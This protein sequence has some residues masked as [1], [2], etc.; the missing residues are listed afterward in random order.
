MGPGYEILLIVCTHHLRYHHHRRHH[1]HQSPK[2]SLRWTK[3]RWYRKTST[4]GNQPVWSLCQRV[5]VEAIRTLSPRLQEEIRRICVRAGQPDFGRACQVSTLLSRQSK[6]LAVF[7]SM[8]SVSSSRNEWSEIVTLL[9]AL[10]LAAKLVKTLAEGRPQGSITGHAGQSADGTGTITRP[11][12]TR[13]RT[14]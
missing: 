14:I 12:R 10:Y 9:C 5:P 2:K 4:R 6:T 8:Q 1:Q 13:R 7:R 3:V 11:P